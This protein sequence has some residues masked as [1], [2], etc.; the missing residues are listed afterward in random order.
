[1]YRQCL[2]RL[3]QRTGGRSG[4]NVF[5]PTLSA[6]A[7]DFFGLFFLFFFWEGTLP[8]SGSGTSLVP[9]REDGSDSRDE[10]WEIG[11]ED[12]ESAVSRRNLFS[13]ARSRELDMM[14]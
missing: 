13:S 14:E 1:M 12:E 9:S 4:S 7:L 6:L 10:G 2:L 3:I 11:T 5:V 8:M